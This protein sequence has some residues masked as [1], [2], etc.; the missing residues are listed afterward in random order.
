MAHNVFASL[1]TITDSRTY[2]RQ[3]SVLTALLR[4]LELRFFYHRDE[5][6]LVERDHQSGEPLGDRLVGAVELNRKILRQ[7]RLWGRVVSTACTSVARCW[8][9]PEPEAGL[10][11]GRIVDCSDL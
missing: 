5:R 8:G 3:R 11:S 7:G 1:V 2:R 9:K 10:W 4:W 6:V